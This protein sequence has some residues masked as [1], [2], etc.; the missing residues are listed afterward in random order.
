MSDPLQ[1]ALI[2][3]FVGLLNLIFAYLARREAAAARKIGVE[4]EHKINSRLDIIIHQ[5]EI[6][7]HAAGVAEEKARQRGE[8]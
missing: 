7:A 8:P 2:T 4:L 5:A 3:G 6:I 1:S